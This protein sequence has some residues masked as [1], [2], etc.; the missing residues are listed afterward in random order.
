ML[1]E[2][3]AGSCHPFPVFL[4]QERKA[5]GYH[6]ASFWIPHSS[7]GA[8]KL[9]DLSMWDP[10]RSPSLLYIYRR[11]LCLCGVSVAQPCAVWGLNGSKSII[12]DEA[13]Q[14]IVIYHMF[15]ISVLSVITMIFLFTIPFILLSYFGYAQNSSRTDKDDL[16]GPLSLLPGPLGS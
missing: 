7:P 9:Q 10:S 3:R 6:P 14:S 2:E 1:W 11:R 8:S 12:Q 16:L 5:T 15:S 13:A 4:S